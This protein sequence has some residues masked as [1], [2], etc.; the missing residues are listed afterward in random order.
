[1]HYRAYLLSFD[2]HIKKG[3]SVEC[4]D[5]AEAFAAIPELVGTYQTAELW[6]GSRRVGQWSLP[7]PNGEWVEEGSA[8]A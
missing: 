2:G 8:F 3:C 1:M 6:C 5:D 4:S 7:E